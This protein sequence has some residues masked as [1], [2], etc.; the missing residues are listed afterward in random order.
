[1]SLYIVVLSLKFNEL[2]DKLQRF[3]ETSISSANVGNIFNNVRELLNMKQFTFYDPKL[4]L[5]KDYQKRT[6]E[7]ENLGL[8]GVIYFQETIQVLK[9]YISIDYWKE[10]CQDAINRLI[11]ELPD[12][13]QF[14]YNQKENYFNPYQ[15]EL[16]E[17]TLLASKITKTDTS[18]Q[19]IEKIGSNYTYFTINN[20]EYLCDGVP[21]TN[22]MI[23]SRFSK[24]SI[25]IFDN[26]EEI[27]ILNTTILESSSLVD[28]IWI[29]IVHANYKIN[30]IQNMFYIC[31]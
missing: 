7:Y 24:D 12:V 23:F 5:F 11:S 8:S 13:D 16:D 22:P 17:L 19:I 27:H 1:M 6:D 4:A 28:R 2:Q 3:E 10:W 21:Y 26:F 30:V 31:K 9:Y 29:Y 14:F 18:E 20:E 25:Y 15:Y